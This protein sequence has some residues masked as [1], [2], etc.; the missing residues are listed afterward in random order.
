M[1]KNGPELLK[2]IYEDLNKTVDY[3]ELRVMQLYYLA[4]N[5]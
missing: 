4:N 1:K 5:K 2:P 3:S